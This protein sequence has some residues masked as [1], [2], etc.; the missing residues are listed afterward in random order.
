[1]YATTTLFWVQRSDFNFV[2]SLQAKLEAI[3]SRTRGQPSRLRCAVGERS[4]ELAINASSHNWSS[5]TS[6]ASGKNVYG[7]L[8]GINLDKLATCKSE[9]LD[10]K[11]LLQ[12][13]IDWRIC[14]L[15]AVSPHF[16]RMQGGQLAKVAALDC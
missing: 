15:T 8:Q 9:E 10:L 2:S 16:C 6:G 11:C 1:M 13:F 4:L 12:A 3:Y 7:F 5:D 14:G